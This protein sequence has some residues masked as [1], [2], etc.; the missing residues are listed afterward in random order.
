MMKSN[1]LSQ[2]EDY[3]NNTLGSAKKTYFCSIDVLVTL[4]C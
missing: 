2:Q 4:Q 1:Y 3:I